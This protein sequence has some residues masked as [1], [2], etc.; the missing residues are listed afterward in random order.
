M[1]M[2]KN[3]V[4]MGTVASAMALYMECTTVYAEPD[5]ATFG[6][7]VNS[8]MAISIKVFQT[9]KEQLYNAFT[10][11]AMISPFYWFFHF[12]VR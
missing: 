8:V 10:T 7:V 11:S 9:V 3:T 12:P 1:A 2:M 5:A 6:L 4:A